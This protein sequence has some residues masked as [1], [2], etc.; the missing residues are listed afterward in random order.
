MRTVARRRIL[1]LQPIA[2]HIDD[3]ADDA[4]VIDPGTPCDSGKCGEIRAIWR[5]LSRNKSPIAASFN[6]DRE[7][8]L[9]RN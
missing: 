2:D 8:H 7:S 5:S 6:G 9:K 3:A 1:P 4:L